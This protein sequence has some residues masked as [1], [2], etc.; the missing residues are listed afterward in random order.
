[1]LVACGSPEPQGPAAAEPAPTATPA[2]ADF[3]IVTD[4]PAIVGSLEE[5]VERSPLILIG[6][7]R[8]EAG[9]VNTARLEE[10]PTQPDP[11]AF[12]L[13]QVYRMD[14]EE[15]VK[16]SGPLDLNIVNGEGFLSSRDDIPVVPP[17]SAAEMDCIRAAYLQYQPLRIGQRYLFFVN[18]ADYFDPE[19]DYAGTAFGHPW[20]FLLPEGGVARQESPYDEVDELFS[21]MAS[22]DLVEAVTELMASN[23]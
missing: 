22:E 8:E 7:V 2:C 3:P 11:Y 20:R 4:D 10:D 18:I 15:Y 1:M 16:G 13:G 21:A 14:V 6:R 23:R 17:E 9:I 5:L 12:G 19:V